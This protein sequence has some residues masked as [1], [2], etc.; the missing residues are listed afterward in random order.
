MRAPGEDLKGLTGQVKDLSELGPPNLR[1]KFFELSGKAFS[2]KDISEPVRGFDGQGQ[3]YTKV[4]PHMGL[5]SS[6]AEEFRPET[7]EMFL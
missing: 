1:G 6:E 5:W 4:L 3:A 7:S 2:S